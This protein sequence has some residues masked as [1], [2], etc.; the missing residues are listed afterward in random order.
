MSNPRLD[1]AYAAQA[2]AIRTRVEAFA[3]ARFAAGQY[4]DADMARFVSQVAPVVLAGRRQVSALT[5]SYLTQ[6]LKSAGI[7]IPVGKPLDTDAL[8]GVPVE[9][10]L[11]RPFVTVRSKIYDIGID[12]AVKAGSA[13]LTD[14]ILTDMQMA[15]T[16]T[17]QNVFGRT[18]GFKT[19]AR[20]LSGGKNC[21]LCSVASTQE[22]HKE[23]LMPIHPGC[24]C[25]VEPITHDNPWNQEAADQR[26]T[27]THAAVEERLGVSDSGAR[28]PD[29][30]KQ[31]IVQEHG[32]IGP[33]LAVR[34]Q[35]FSGRSVMDN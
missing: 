16:Y 9:E 1:A 6:V 22:Y 13:R 27:D 32:E 3:S 28:E 2:K 20:V 21:G 33:V 30:R 25:G 12:D 18:D 5:D 34:G 10:V 15:K 19:F 17:A 11:A 14:I 23:D 4:R 29:Y 35:H 7:K 31:L 24:D 26:L 8:R